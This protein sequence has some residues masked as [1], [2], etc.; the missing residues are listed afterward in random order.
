M[1][2]IQELIEELR[3][4]DANVAGVLLKAK[5]LL[6][7]RHSTEFNEWIESELSGYQESQEVPPY[8][9][10]PTKSTG[11]YTVPNDGAMNEIDI[12]TESLPPEVKEF[13]ETLIVRDGV[14]ALEAHRDED[15]VN[16]WPED[17]FKLIQGGPAERRGLILTGAYQPIPA[18]RYTEILSEVKTTLVG[19]LRSVEGTLEESNP[20]EP[21]G[22]RV[23]SQAINIASFNYIQGDSNTVATGDQVNQQVSNVQKNDV[24]SLLAYLREHGVAENDLQDL[25]DAIASEPEVSDGNFGPKAGA[26]LGG[27]LAKA[28]EGALRV[29]IETAIR[30]FRGI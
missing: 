10:S 28:S 12:P 11:H 24:D 21:S 3:Q 15:G 13:A 16:W 25:S 14:G 8:R 19:F 5:A 9:R 17:M 23:A 7:E 20:P 2:A 22:G 26:C 29:V 4:S 1:D 30:S 18:T 6:D 27:I